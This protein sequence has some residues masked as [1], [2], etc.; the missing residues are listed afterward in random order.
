VVAVLSAVVT[1]VWFI[2]T[3]ANDMKAHAREIQLTQQILSNDFMELSN[4]FDAFAIQ[5]NNAIEE[6]GEKIDTTN[7]NLESLLKILCD[8]DPKPPECSNSDN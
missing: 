2:M 4:N 8:Q 1:F 6:L 7:S 5:T 3:E